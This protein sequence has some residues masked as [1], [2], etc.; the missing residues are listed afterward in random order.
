ML[1]LGLSCFAHLDIFASSFVGVVRQVAVASINV[2]VK[3]QSL[4][5]RAHSSSAVS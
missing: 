1:L 3:C 2:Q 5:E 4:N